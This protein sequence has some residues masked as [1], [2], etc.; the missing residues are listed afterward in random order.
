MWIFLQQ[1]LPA[2]NCWL[3]FSHAAVTWLVY[4]QLLQSTRWPCCDG[5]LPPVAV[6]RDRMVILPQS[7]LYVKTGEAEKKDGAPSQFPPALICC[8]L[9]RGQLWER[10]GNWSTCGGLKTSC[11]ASIILSP[12]LLL[13]LSKYSIFPPLWLFLSPSPATVPISWAEMIHALIYSRA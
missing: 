3:D 11:F 8:G 10:G 6:F 1:A 7:G 4:L 2:C 5:S 13:F 12:P 9:N